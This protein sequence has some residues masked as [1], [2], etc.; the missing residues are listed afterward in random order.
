MLQAVLQMD[1]DEIRCS[2]SAAAV[3]TLPGAGGDAFV[4]ALFAENVTAGADG[5]V[6]EAVATYCAE[7]NLLQY[8]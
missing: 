5:G 6:F 4:G 3:G 8:G 1:R 2:K 7:G